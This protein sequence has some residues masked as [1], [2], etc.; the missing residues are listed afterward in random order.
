MVYCGKLGRPFGVRGELVVFWNNEN[1]PLSSGAEIYLQ[2]KNG[3]KNFCIT[4]LSSSGKKN[5]IAFQGISSPEEAKK[6][7]H[8]K[9][10]LPEDM[11]PSLG[12]DEYYSYQLLGMQVY[13]EEGKKLGTL[14][15]IFNT[16]SNDVY[17]VLPEGKKTG[18]EWLIPAIKDI[19]LK[20]DLQKNQMIVH[21]CSGLFDTEEKKE[22]SSHKKDS[23]AL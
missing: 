15:N 2:E 14:T 4:K 13:N 7:T 23:D 18:N 12:D 11:L 21:E 22:A 5:T 8:G 16:G 19:V 6:L 1:P 3:Y 17:E 9:L 20:V 10:Y